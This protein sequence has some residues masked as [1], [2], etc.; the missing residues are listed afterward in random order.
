[1]TGTGARRARPVSQRPR[2]QHFLRSPALAAEIVRD[3]RISL[4]DLVL[5]IGAG[6]G[7][8]TVEL[9][10]T[11]RR[12]LAVELDPA[13]AARLRRR[14]EGRQV[15]VVEGDALAQPLPRE[16]FR[17]FGNLP[18]HTTAAILYRLLDDPAV[19]LTMADVIVEWGAARKRAAVWPSTLLGVVWGAWFTFAA[20]RH[21]PAGCF[22]PRP[23]VDAG[24]LAIRRRD[25]PLIRENE[26]APFRR[27]VRRGFA[28]PS[29]REGLSGRISPRAFKRLADV[30]GFPRT[31]APRDL[32]VHQWTAVFRAV[33]PEAHT[34]ARRPV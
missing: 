16:P 13:L 4:D 33:G 23:S 10:R 1:V 17:V 9:A 15:Q 31:A 6:D 27:F 28:V 14:F 21:L 3:A 32:D 22:A 19:P 29:L 26:G 5:E 7:R 12:V 2:S 30:Y 8:L 18:F 24:V 20:E 11:A 25:R 34:R